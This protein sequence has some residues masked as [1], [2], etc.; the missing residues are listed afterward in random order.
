MTVIIRFLEG[1]GVPKGS[2]FLYDFYRFLNIEVF[3]N[4]NIRYVL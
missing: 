4:V 2:L 1:L 3:G